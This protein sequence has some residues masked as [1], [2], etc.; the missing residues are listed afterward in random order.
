M[1]IVKQTFTAASGIVIT[2]LGLNWLTKSCIM[3]CTNGKL[4]IAF[5]EGDMLSNEH[6]GASSL[7]SLE[8]I[9]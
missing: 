8:V 3:S 2:V 1:I 9:L 4:C 7:F 5:L 6:V